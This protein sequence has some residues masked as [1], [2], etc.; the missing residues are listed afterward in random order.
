MLERVAF[1]WANCAS[2]DY[3]PLSKNT[4]IYIC[5]LARTICSTLAEPIEHTAAQRNAA[6]AFTH[7]DGVGANWGRE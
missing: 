7:L 1:S 3:T 5:T 2:V 6:Q 4:Q